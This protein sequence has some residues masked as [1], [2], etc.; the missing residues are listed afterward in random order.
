MRM[1]QKI[2]VE[3]YGFKDLEARKKSLARRAEQL[4]NE[5]KEYARK[6]EMMKNYPELLEEFYETALKNTEEL[7]AQGK[8]RLDG[9]TGGALDNRGLRQVCGIVMAD[10]RVYST[11]DDLCLEKVFW[12]DAWVGELVDNLKKAGLSNTA[13]KKFYDTIAK[14]PDDKDAILSEAG[15]VALKNYSD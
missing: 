9:K 10:T 4:R 7:L 8:I 14:F 2:E 11:N 15:L 12:A 1:K 6:A 5:A 13:R 3:T